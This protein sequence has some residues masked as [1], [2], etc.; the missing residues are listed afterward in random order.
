MN[1]NKVDFVVDGSSVRGRRLPTVSMS[2]VQNRSN[3]DVNSCGP[4][5]DTVTTGIRIGKTDA[6]VSATT[7]M[8]TGRAKDS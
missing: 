5:L 6:V 1:P 8:A 2:E 4:H 3:E 7:V